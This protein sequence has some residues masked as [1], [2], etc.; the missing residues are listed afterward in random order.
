MSQFPANSIKSVE[1]ITNP[2]SRYD[3]TGVGGIINVILKKNEALGFNGQVNASAGTRD[4]YQA[5]INLNYGTE[6]ANFYTSFNW[7]D[8]R[9]LEWG[10]GTRTANIPGFSPTIDQESRGEELEKSY[11]ARIG[12]DYFVSSKGTLGVYF[13]GNFDDENEFGTT[14]QRFLDGAGSLD[15]SFVRRTDELSSSA[16]YEGGLNYTVDIDTLGQRL[17]AALSYSYDDR[18]QE[19][20]YFQDAFG[21]GGESFPDNRLVQVNDRPRTSNLYVAQLDYE[22]PLA[23]GGKIEG[24]LKA[25]LGD[26]TWSQEFSQGDISNDF[27]PTPVDTLTDSYDFSEDVYAAYFIY[28]N[29]IGKL[30]YQAGLRAEYT[31]TLGETAR[32]QEVI[33]NDYF[34]VFPSAFLS[35]EL[36]TE[37]ELT[38]N[39]TRRI[40]R[41]SIWD[42]APIYRVRDQF[43][44][45]IGNPYLQPEF[46]DSYELGY[47][48]GWER[49]LLN[50]AVY[51]RFST[52][53]E[54]RVQEIT[55]DNVSIQSRVNADTRSSTGLE[56]VNQFQVS[57]AV[58]MTLTGNFFYSQINAENVE[59][60]FTNENFSWTLSLL[61]NIL[62]P[63]WFSIQVQ[64][65]YRG[66]IVL[67]QGQIEPNGS[68]NIGL[69]R[70]LF[71]NKATISVNVSDIFNTRNFRV[72]A[73]DPRF[74]EERFRQRESRIGTISFTYRFGGFKEKREDRGSRRDGGDYGGDDF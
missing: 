29:R 27:M 38:L 39:Y 52:N 60:G 73:D 2:S 14:D 23:S 51:H 33:P 3:A 72:I 11:L 22:K 31:E 63:D 6:K 45:S 18:S 66:P 36:G 20:N 26:W 28:R 13:Q 37:N 19:E 17:Y 49:Y 41:P 32:N 71:D 57:N 59:A 25:T 47:M 10:D 12:M 4:K 70:D 1:L 65:N 8:R 64:G 42:L 61:S 62:I 53:V 9:R 55:D 44:L 48:K 21:A 67:P 40:S 15:S 74:Q 7:Q 34:N 35:Y 50:A 5:G 30:G 24:G 68:L 16:N 58:D 56:L 43:N 54:T 69:R 46:T